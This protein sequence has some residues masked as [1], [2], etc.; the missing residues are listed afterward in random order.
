MFKSAQS[1]GQHQ[2]LQEIESDIKSAAAALELLCSWNTGGQNSQNTDCAHVD[3]VDSDDIKEFCWCFKRCRWQRWSWQC[4]GVAAIGRGGGAPHRRWGSK[5]LP[6]I[7]A[8]PLS[9]SNLTPYITSLQTLIDYH[10]SQTVN[11]Q[12]A[13]SDIEPHIC[14]ICRNF[15][16]PQFQG[17][18]YKALRFFWILNPNQNK[19]R[20]ISKRTGRHLPFPRKLEPIKCKTSNLT[21]FESVQAVW[22]THMPEQLP[23]FLVPPSLYMCTHWYSLHW[24]RCSIIKRDT[25]YLKYLTATTCK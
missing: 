11:F 17:Q 3:I 14:K 10:M 7:Q 8:S 18:R 4:W 15:E 6:L 13:M 9:S 16:M 21:K 23:P 2:F 24:C 1:C 5:W 19:Q 20:I 25:L 12:W 22:S